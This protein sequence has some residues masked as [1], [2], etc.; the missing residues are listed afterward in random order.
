ME[1][2]NQITIEL[3]KYENKDYTMFVYE[4]LNYFTPVLSIKKP[5]HWNKCMLA[6]SQYLRGRKI[7]NVFQKKSMETQILDKESE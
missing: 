6:L 3:R 5:V 1:K 2:F 7:I 4:K